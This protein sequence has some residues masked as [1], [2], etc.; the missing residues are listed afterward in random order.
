MFIDLEHKMPS[1][2]NDQSSIEEQWTI[3]RDTVHNTALEHLG[4]T[5]RR[6]Q[7]W[8]DEN[9]E[10]I[11]LLLVEKRRLLRAHQDDSLSTSKRSAFFNVRRTVQKRLREVQDAWLS[12]KADEIQPW[13]VIQPLLKAPKA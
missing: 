5:T 3:F 8:F 12:A 13:C 6:D 9:D 7:D 10:E 1:L 4:A 2:T 11:Q